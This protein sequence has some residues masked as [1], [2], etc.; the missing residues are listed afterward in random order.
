MLHPGFAVPEKLNYDYF[1]EKILQN[2]NTQMRKK[3][4][5]MLLIKVH[6]YNKT[7]R[8]CVCYAQKISKKNNCITSKKVNPADKTTD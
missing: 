1:R 5:N 3:V 2:L 4:Q 7:T 8:K 6:Y